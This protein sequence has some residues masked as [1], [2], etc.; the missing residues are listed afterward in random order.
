MVPDLVSW[1]TTSLTPRTYAWRT[2]GNDV[3]YDFDYADAG[4]ATMIQEF[5]YQNGRVRVASL[6]MLLV[7][8]APC[9]SNAVSTPD[10]LL[11]VPRRKVRPEEDDVTTGALMAL[12]CEACPHVGA[13]CRRAQSME[14]HLHMHR[15][16]VPRAYLR[17][18][19]ELAFYRSVTASTKQPCISDANAQCFVR[20]GDNVCTPQ[21]CDRAASCWVLL[22]PRHPGAG[23]QPPVR[24]LPDDVQPLRVWL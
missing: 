10:M 6:H 15:C 12:T 1:F 13:G 17:L 21:L 5:A 20:P 24:L 11:A 8:Y 22:P 16:A 9:T 14:R 19:R 3:G 23:S 4:G 18:D 2:T 7:G